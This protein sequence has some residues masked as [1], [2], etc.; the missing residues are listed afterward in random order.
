MRTFRTA[1]TEAEARHFLETMSR[2]ELIANNI[3]GDKLAWELHER[4]EHLRAL[5][6]SAVD[7]AKLAVDRSNAGNGANHRVDLHIKVNA[8]E[9]G[10]EDY[11]VTSWSGDRIEILDEDTP[12]GSEQGRRPKSGACLRRSR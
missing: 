7:I 12:A 9:V 6:Q 1:D 5:A 3:A 10:S 2:E 11:K 4:C 8:P